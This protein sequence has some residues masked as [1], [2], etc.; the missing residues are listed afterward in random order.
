MTNDKLKSYSAD[1]IHFLKY[2]TFNLVEN[3]K[4]YKNSEVATRYF[5]FFNS[6]EPF[7][8]LL[9]GEGVQP[10]YIDSVFGKVMEL[11]RDEMELERL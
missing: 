2:G 6:P 1:I 3:Q 4:P 10:Q 5:A 9:A 8:N 7:F 11:V